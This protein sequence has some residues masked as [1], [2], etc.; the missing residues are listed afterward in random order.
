MKPII[1]IF[2]FLLMGF[3]ILHAQTNKVDEKNRFCIFTLGEDISLRSVDLKNYKHNDDGTDTYYYDGIGCQSAFEMEIGQPAL[4]YKNSEL[5]SLRTTCYLNSGQLLILKENADAMYGKP[6]SNGFD[7]R[8]KSTIRLWKG[9]KAVV[10]LVQKQMEGGDD[11]Y[12]YFWVRK[13]N[14]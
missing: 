13:A 9:N 4:T 10:S 3:S 14:Q 12:V 7:E 1:T 5:I 2:S 11:W 6:T 8:E